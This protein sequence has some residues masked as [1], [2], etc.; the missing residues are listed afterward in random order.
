MALGCAE[1]VITRSSGSRR[2]GYS[3]ANEPH[4]NW[5]EPLV[6]LLLTERKTGWEADGQLT[7]PMLAERGTG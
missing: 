2:I 6:G 4:A 3:R 1:L 7:G 5:G